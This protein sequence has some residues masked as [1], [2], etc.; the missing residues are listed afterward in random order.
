MISDLSSAFQLKEIRGWE[1]YLIVSIDSA[2]EKHH[3][4]TGTAGGNTPVK[5]L[6]FDNTGCHNSMIVQKSVEGET[7]GRKSSK[8]KFIVFAPAI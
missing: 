5:R 4:F 1:K 8:Q 7:R 6:V 2:K 3:A